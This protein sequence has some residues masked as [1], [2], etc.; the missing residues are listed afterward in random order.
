MVMKE[1]QISPR[2]ATGKKAQHSMYIRYELEAGR[3]H[4][5]NR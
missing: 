3:G 5:Q 1:T 2:D 4:S